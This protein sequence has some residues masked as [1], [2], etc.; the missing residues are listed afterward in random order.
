LNGAAER[1]VAAVRGLL[2]Q[3]GL[4]AIVD[5]HTHFMPKRVM[6]K[7]WAYFDGIGPLVGRQWPIE[8]RID[9]VE[10]VER[11]R[12]FGVAAFTSLVYPHKPDMA[13]WLNS[14]ATEF[15]AEV[16]ECVHTATFYPEPSAPAYVRRVIDAGARV[17][18]AHIQVGDYSATDPL[19]QPVWALLEETQIPTVIHAGSG[20]RPGRHTGPAPIAEIL[21]RHPALRLIVAHMG[22]P[23]YREFIEFARRY[24]GVYLDTTMV[25]TQFT[26]QTDPFPP[27]AR[28]ALVELADKVLFGSDF[29]NI[30][31]PY[32]HALESI[33]A[34]E[35]GDEWCRKVLC[36][37]ARNLFPPVGTGSDD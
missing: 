22:L 36:R 32:H 28:P 5:V 25:F 14:W 27:E 13:E 15:A 33:T 9:E 34:L 16:P 12:Q 31:Y 35:L 24:P 8:Y 11:L 10:R 20:P 6:D 3:L 1:E 30:P 2:D 29:P 17:F 21:R 37:N 26:E 23:E 18:K 7:V 19:L 4:D